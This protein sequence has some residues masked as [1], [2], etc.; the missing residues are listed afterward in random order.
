MRRLS[1][2]LMTGMLALAGCSQQVG[3]PTAATLP[4]PVRIISEP[5]EVHDG[6][7]WQ[8]ERRAEQSLVSDQK[9]RCKGDIVTIQ[10]VESIDAA[11]SRSTT[12]SRTQ[13]VA[14]AVTQLF[15]PGWGTLKGAPAN[16]NYTS[17]RDGSGTGTLADNQ[18]VKATLAAQVLEVMPNGNLI[19]TASKEVSVSGEVQVVTLTGI[20]RQKD[21][22]PDDT[23]LST[24]LAEA[25]IHITGSGPLNDAQR[26]TLVTRALDW[27]NLF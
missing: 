9:A 21:I 19:L 7:L 14:A 18:T 26:R 27:I 13:S 24:S 2:L 22:T 25:R 3:R 12:T 4:E 11:H 8:P 5:V 17:K 23:V 1:I 10:V 15:F 16:V 20:A 6:S